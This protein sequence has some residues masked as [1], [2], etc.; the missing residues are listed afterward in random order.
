M[1][2]LLF[3][4]FNRKR[5]KKRRSHERWERKRERKMW[6]E[7]TSELVPKHVSLNFCW[8]FFSAWFCFENRF[9]F[10]CWA[11]SHDEHYCH[12]CCCSVLFLF[13]HTTTFMC[14]IF[15]FFLHFDICADFILSGRDSLKHVYSVDLNWCNI[16][17]I[18]GFP[19]NSKNSDVFT[20]CTHTHTR[21]MFAVN[22]TAYT[23]VQC[24]T[25]I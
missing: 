20:Q 13:K 15:R 22:V 1:R 10:W 23:H 11:C 19:L 14:S 8:M 3:Q 9:H 17:F 25:Y 5:N 16:I 7:R 6:W 4:V 24:T 21:I 18:S 12:H 2:L